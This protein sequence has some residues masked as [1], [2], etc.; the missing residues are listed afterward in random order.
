[1]MCFTCGVC[2]F[3]RGAL[4]VWNGVRLDSAP[5]T[6]PMNLRSLLTTP[7]VRSSP[8]FVYGMLGLCLVLLAVNVSLRMHA[9]AGLGFS[10]NLNLVIVLMM[11]LNHVAFHFPWPLRVMVV[12][13]VASMA[14]AVFGLVY[15]LGAL[16]MVP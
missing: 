5:G 8:V 2:G 14:W 7:P 3:D 16:L 9:T 4:R 15:A 10:A 13:R 11:L 6:M 1:M 12:L